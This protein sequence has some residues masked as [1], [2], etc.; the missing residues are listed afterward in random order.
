M[1]ILKSDT[2][3]SKMKINNKNPLR[4]P[5][6]IKVSIYR[7]YISTT[8]LDRKALA[9]IMNKQFIAL[10]K[11]FKKRQK[12]SLKKQVQSNLFIQTLDAI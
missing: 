2:R 12:F 11:L 1:D 4:K 10:R 9:G 7:T 8:L 6:A 3:Q 5:K